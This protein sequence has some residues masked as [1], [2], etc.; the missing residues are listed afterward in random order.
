MHPLRVKFLFPHSPMEL[1]KLSTAG[2]QSQMIWWLVFL[3]K[4]P[5]AGESEVRLRTLIPVAEPLHYNYSPVSGSP[6]LGYET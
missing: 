5:Q 4:D 3:V 2:L 6:T 1:P